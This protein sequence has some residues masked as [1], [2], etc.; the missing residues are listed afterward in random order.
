MTNIFASV[1]QVEIPVATQS[2]VLVV[3]STTFLDGSSI[4]RLLAEQQ[5][6]CGSE[7]ALPALFERKAVRD[8]PLSVDEDEQVRVVVQAFLVVIWSPDQTTR[9]TEGLPFHVQSNALILTSHDS[10]PSE[11]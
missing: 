6:Q 3:R 2:E 7:P 4:I 9:T 8:A 10:A 5:S 1:K 11:T